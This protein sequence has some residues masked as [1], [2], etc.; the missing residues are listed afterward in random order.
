MGEVGRG[1][2]CSPPDVSPIPLVYRV[3]PLG[4]IRDGCVPRR[5]LGSLFANGWG[6]IP[7]LFVVWPGAFQP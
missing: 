7:T 4:V 6:C 3:L 5:T 2:C 1:A